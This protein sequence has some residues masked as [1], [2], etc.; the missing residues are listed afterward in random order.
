MKWFGIGLLDD[1]LSEK[2]QLDSRLTLETAVTIA[3]QS[4]KV[5]KQQ[6]MVRQKVTDLNSNIMETVCTSKGVDKTKFT[7]QSVDNSTSLRG[8]SSVHQRQQKCSRCGRK[9]PNHS[10]QQCPAKDTICHWYVA[11][12]AI[13][14]ICV[15]HSPSKYVLSLL[16]F[17]T[18]NYWELSL[19]P[20]A[21][22]SGMLLYC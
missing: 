5:H 15:G 8:Q 20:T 12:K 2:L 17:P 9:T 18:T 11:R 4:D 6:T 19:L 21:A 14:S 7:N 16:K 10:R 3:H 22:I 13:T 1:A